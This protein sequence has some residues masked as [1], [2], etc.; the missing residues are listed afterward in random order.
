MLL[1]SGFCH[2]IRMRM[3]RVA[4]ESDLLSVATAPFAKQEVNAQSQPMAKRKLVV[5]S[6]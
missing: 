5:E 6:L 3:G 2:F 4:H 1:R